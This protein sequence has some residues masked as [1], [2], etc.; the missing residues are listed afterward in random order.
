MEKI[1]LMKA[2]WKDVAE[3]NKEPLREYFLPEA[4]IRWHNTNELF[5][6]EEF[7]R[8]NCEYPGEWRGEV[9]R[10]EEAGESMIT[11]TRVYSPDNQISLH[12]VSFFKFK[13]GKIQSLDEYWGDDTL[14][15]VWRQDMKIGTAIK[16]TQ[17]KM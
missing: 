5:T 13:E 4:Q 9:E 3:Q 8:A 12:A 1:K 15:P 6:V 17:Q 7:L 2:Y 10:V 11:V 14:P 16:N